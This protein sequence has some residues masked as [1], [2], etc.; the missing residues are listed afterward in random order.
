MPKPEDAQRSLIEHFAQITLEEFQDRY[1]KYAGDGDSPLLPT[2]FD[3]GSS[4]LIL[5]QR[6]PAPLRL[7]AYLASALTALDEQQRNM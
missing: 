2:T 4:D 6:E 5:W 7:E 1:E 3:R